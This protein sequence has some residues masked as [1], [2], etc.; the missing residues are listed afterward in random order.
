MQFIQNDM[1]LVLQLCYDKVSMVFD[2][3]TYISDSAITVLFITIIEGG[4]N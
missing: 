2:I 4:Y 1:C 3:F